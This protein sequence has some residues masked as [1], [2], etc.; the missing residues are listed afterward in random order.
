MSRGI[1][2][3]LLLLVASCSTI[4]EAREQVHPPLPR[5]YSPCVERPF[6]VENSKIWISYYDSVNL[7]ICI[8]DSE[9]YIT[10]LLNVVC[11]Y[12]K[13]EKVCQRLKTFSES[14]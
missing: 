2:C 11:Y 1:I 9:R 3:S 4:P 7:A 10:E 12:N 14:Q 6:K 8:K 5:P 13:K